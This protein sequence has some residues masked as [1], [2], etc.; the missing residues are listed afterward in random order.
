MGRLGGSQLL[1]CPSTFRRT[2][3]RIRLTAGQTQLSKYVAAG[4][5]TAVARREPHFSMF[6]C[7]VL[8]QVATLLSSC[9]ATMWYF[10]VAHFS[11]L[12][13]LAM[14]RRTYLYMF[15]CN[16]VLQCGVVHSVVH[17]TDSPPH[18]TSAVAT[19]PV[20][21]SSAKKLQRQLSKNHSP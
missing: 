6:N 17:H 13:T 5:L 16:V 18:L 10:S 4:G 14:H 1:F 7:N 9:S 12:Y 8:L 20:S 19:C 11:S 15:G 21:S 2:R 3:C